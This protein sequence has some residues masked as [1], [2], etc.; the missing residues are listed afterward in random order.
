MAGRERMRLTDAALSRLRPRERE[1]TVWDN[2]LPGLGVRVRPSGGRELCSVAGVR[3][4][5]ETHLARPSLLEVHFRRPPGMPCA[6]SRP[7]AGGNSLTGTRGSAVPSLRCGSLEGS[8]FRPV[9]AL[10]EE[11]RSRRAGK[12]DIAGLRVEAARPDHAGTGQAAGSIRLAG[13]RRAVAN[14]GLGVLR[15][16]MNF[17]IACGHI[18]M[19]PTRSIRPNRRPRLSRFLSREE[20]GRLHGVLDMQTRKGR[21]QQADIIRLLLLT[22]C[23]RSE[24][25]AAALVGNPCQRAGPRGQQDGAEKGSSQHSGQEH[26]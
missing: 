9:Q 4:P 14:N 23:R 2:R 7:E 13:P 1:Y 12:P 20:I 17:A 24:N 22:G 19:N 21:R 3:W 26:S 5:L 15:Q 11:G 6:P 16:I 25:R 10:D 18:D 8:S